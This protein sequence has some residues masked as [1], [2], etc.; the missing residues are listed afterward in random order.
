VRFGTGIEV[1]GRLDSYL[2]GTTKDKA[3][4]REVVKRRFIAG[5]CTAAEVRK[6]RWS[7]GA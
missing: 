1:I 5:S 3:E 2:F 4:V 7:E 6:S